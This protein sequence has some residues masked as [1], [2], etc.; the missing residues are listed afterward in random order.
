MGASLLAIS[1]SQ[2][3]LMSTDTPSSRAG[4]LPQGFIPNWDLYRL[5]GRGLLTAR[6]CS[7]LR[8]SPPRRPWI[9]RQGN[10]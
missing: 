1:V 3:P 2:T 6:F 5:V 9:S 8:T 10:H 7:K 4:S